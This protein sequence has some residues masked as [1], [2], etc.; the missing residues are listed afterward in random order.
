MVAEG[1]YIITAQ[2]C[3]AVQSM[4]VR[5]H[6]VHRG[7]CHFHTTAATS[8]L[9]AQDSLKSPHRVKETLSYGCTSQMTP[10]ALYWAAR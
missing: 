5:N 1:E 9:R 6:G 8:T 7:P 10:T 2:Q 4:V 3:S